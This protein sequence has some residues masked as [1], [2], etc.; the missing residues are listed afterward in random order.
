VA[1]DCVA[2]PTDD[3]PCSPDSIPDCACVSVGEY[4]ACTIA[5]DES[6]IDATRTMT[7]GGSAAVALVSEP[8]AAVYATTLLRSL[9][10]GA[11]T[12]L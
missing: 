10:L 9:A 12:P 5:A 7:V 11:S 1:Q 2:Q 6:Y 4:V 3:K 8:V